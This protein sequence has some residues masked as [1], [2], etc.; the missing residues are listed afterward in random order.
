MPSIP[1]DSLRFTPV[2]VAQINAIRYKYKVESASAEKEVGEQWLAAYGFGEPG[3]PAAATPS[4]V[5]QDR[6]V[7]GVTR[8]G[9]ELGFLAV[10]TLDSMSTPPWR[11]GV[12]VPKADYL[13]SVGEQV[14][15]VVPLALLL[16]V[17][18]LLAVAGFAILVSRPLEKLCAS[19]GLLADGQFGESVPIP[20]GREVGTL[21]Q[22]FD[23]MRMKL[24]A[25]FN[26]L[27]AE[28]QRATATL[29]SIEDGVIVID[30]ASNVVLLNKAAE[31]ITGHKQSEVLNESIESVL[32]ARDARSGQRFT[33]ESLHAELASSRRDGVEIVVAPV[34]GVELQVRL[35]VTMLVECD[36]SQGAVLTLHDRTLAQQLRTELA[37]AAS[38][39]A[40]TELTNRCELI[41]RITRAIDTASESQLPSA[42]ALFDLVDFASINEEIGYSGGDELLRQIAMLLLDGSKS[43][44][45]VTVAR[46]GGDEFAVLVEGQDVQSMMGFFEQLRSDVE[47]FQFG[48][49]DRGFTV[50]VSVGALDLNVETLGPTAALRDAGTACLQA[51][52]EGSYQV[53]TFQVDTD[54]GSAVELDRVRIS[55]AI[56][57]NRFELVAQKVVSLKD[58]FHPDVE[59]L[60]RL[61]DIDGELLMPATFLPSAERLGIAN[62]LDR[63]I[64]GL[65]LTALSES[66]LAARGLTSCAINLSGQTLGDPTFL[67]WILDALTRYAVDPKTLIFEVTETATVTHLSVAKRLMSAL[68]EKGIQFS[69]DDFGTGLCSFAY[70]KELPIDILKIDGSFVMAMMHERRSETLVRSMGELGKSLELKIVAECIEDEATLEQLRAMGVDKA[71]GFY[72]HRPERF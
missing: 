46:T 68:S 15:R 8:V 50:A 69:L 38:H 28:R 5:T 40:L 66:S 47:A 64:I 29:Q 39:D 9:G 2:A 30:Q 11:V 33:C 71:Q 4:L 59:I 10:A 34:Y 7:S 16:I 6:V 26:A 31:R 20:V 32:M 67:P 18:A 62:K 23:D 60:V 17:G 12:F 27:D 56:A 24:G 13:S 1:L 45:S 63:H 37:W 35:G 70:L 55:K 57:E 21:A 51:K 49:I 54:P 43:Q 41:A 52:A 42:L 14:N 72:L 19:V 22:A 65:T 44:P 58:E 36:N 3:A 25:S 61:R 53:S 48:W